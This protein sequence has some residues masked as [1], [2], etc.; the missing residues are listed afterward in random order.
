MT[1][2]EE[3]TTTS[4]ISHHLFDSEDGG[5]FLRVVAASPLEPFNFLSLDD[6]FLL[7]LFL[8]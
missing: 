6:L 4:T 8:I 2:W 3:S 7:L 5:I 1:V